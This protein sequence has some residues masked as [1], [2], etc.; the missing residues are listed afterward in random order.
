MSQVSYLDFPICIWEEIVNL[1]DSKTITSLLMIKFFQSVKIK[2][3]QIKVIKFSSINQNSICYRSVT[4]LKISNFDV[5]SNTELIIPPKLN[6]L[7]LINFQDYAYVR[8]NYLFKIPTLTTLSLSFLDQSGYPKGIS[9]LSLSDLT[10]DITNLPMNLK[11]LTLN[12]GEPHEYHFNVQFPK[13]LEE[14]TI[15]SGG[16]FEDPFQIRELPSILK[17]LTCANCSLP[18]SLPKSITYLSLSNWIDLKSLSS[19]TTLENLETLELHRVN[20]SYEI[21]KFID[22]F[23]TMDKLETFK[24]NSNTLTHLL[25]YG[26][27]LP[28][29]VRK[30]YIIVDFVEDFILSELNLDLNNL[31][32]LSIVNKERRR[33]FE[34]KNIYSTN[35]IE[36][37]LD[38][39]IGVRLFTPNLK[40]VSLLKRF[41]GEITIPKSVEYLRN[42]SKEKRITLEK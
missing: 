7:T 27:S 42:L 38:G 22:L 10:G 21:G 4:N 2:Y 32:Y 26:L 18:R 13:E 17:S 16:D 29:A 9:S 20:F 12:L 35:L 30:L 33:G 36:L 39:K 25:E 37:S 41:R 15:T 14:L 24:I 11:K 6:T 40:T 28:S 23:S 8:E 1:C 5:E 34:S 19:E 31:T 3:Y